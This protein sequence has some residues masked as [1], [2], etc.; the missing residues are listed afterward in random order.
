[1]ISADQLQQDRQLII[2]WARR[3]IP[4]RAISPKSGGRGEKER[5][6]EICR[7][8]SEM[9]I[10]NFTR[11]DVEDD[12]GTVRPNIVVRVGDRPRTLWVVAHIDTVPEGGTWASGHTPPFAATVEGDRIYGRG[13]NDNGH[14][15]FLSLLLLQHARV[16]GR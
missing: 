9:G 8:L 1:M 10:S 3:I 4:I 13:T 5:A 6:D 15:V 11:Y 2:D 7:I 14:A 12:T 16:G